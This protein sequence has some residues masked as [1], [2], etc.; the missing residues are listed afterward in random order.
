[1]ARNSR[2][3]FTA[4]VIA[5]DASRCNR[6]PQP[7]HDEKRWRELARRLAVRR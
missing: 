4:V 7:D 5:G 2:L 6:Q 3:N 1:M